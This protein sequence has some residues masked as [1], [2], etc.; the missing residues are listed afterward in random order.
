VDF[1]ARDIFKK[2]ENSSRVEVPKRKTKTNKKAQKSTLKKG[3]S[4]TGGWGT[5]HKS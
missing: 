2:T 1:H 4:I 5:K 3:D